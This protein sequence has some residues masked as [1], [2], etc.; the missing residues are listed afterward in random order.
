MIFWAQPPLVPGEDE[1]RRWAEEELSRGIYQGD[2]ESLFQKLLNAISE[3]FSRA[4]ASSD[5]PTGSVAIAIVIA[6]LVALGLAFLLYGPLRRARVIKKSSHDVLTD[7]T[8]SAAELRA[9]AAAH[10]SAGQWSLAVLERFRAITRALIER[11]ILD[12]R[13]G[14]TAHEV[15]QTAAPRL[16]DAAADIDRA[17]ALFDRVCYGE[18]LATA[19][20]A[21]W[22]REVDDRIAVTRPNTEAVMA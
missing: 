18:V 9:A 11:A 17:G 7:D 16:P 4:E 12:D 5:V 13:P 1:A 10:E 22:L 19:Q 14:Q 6:L 21:A 8:R 20:E 2:R 15:V 3:F